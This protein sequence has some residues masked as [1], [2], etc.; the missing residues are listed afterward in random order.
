MLKTICEVTIHE[1]DG[2]PTGVAQGEGTYPPLRVTSHES[3]VS[4]VVLGCPNG[5]EVKL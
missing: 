1:V 2:E 5:S 4:M 3:Y